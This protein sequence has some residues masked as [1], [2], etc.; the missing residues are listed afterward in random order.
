MWVRAGDSPRDRSEG[1]IGGMRW[2]CMSRR[3]AGE[4]VRREGRVLKVGGEGRTEPQ[5]RDISRL[6]RDPAQAFLL[7]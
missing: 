3:A 5:P 2:I 7:S 4:A 1:T 6:L